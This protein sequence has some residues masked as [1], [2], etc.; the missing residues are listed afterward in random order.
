MDDKEIPLEFLI[1]QKAE[2][3]IEW[4]QSKGYDMS[5]NWNE[6]WQDSHAKAFTVAKV[7]K[8]DLLQDI[9][10]SWQRA[11]DQGITFEQ[12]RLRIEGTLQRQGWWGRVPVKDV[13]GYEDLTEAQKQVIGD[14]EK[15]VQLGS[16]HR[17]RTIFETN[18]SVAYNSGRWKQ[19]SDNKGHRPYLLYNQLDRPTRRITHEPFDNLVFH[20]DDP[21]WNIIYPPNG[22][23][24]ACRAG[25]LTKAEVKA[26]GLKVVKGTDL[27]GKD[28]M[29]YIEFAKTVIND[30]WQYNPGKAAFSPKLS[31]YDKDL[32]KGFNKE[33]NNV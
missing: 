12:W 20:I 21:I 28:G 2:F 23:Y 13:P 31:D 32:Q 19:Q 26:K 18:N 4:F 16:L 27:M 30:G 22:F 29:T 7:M 11:F 33:N 25:A 10:K 1:K 3:I 17:L 24:C 14:P 8:L 6:V 9:R 5:W 15:L